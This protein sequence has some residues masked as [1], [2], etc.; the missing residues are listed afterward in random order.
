MLVQGK[1]IK[2]SHGMHITPEYD[3]SVLRTADMVIVP[4]WPSPDI[5]PEPQ[6]TEALG[7]LH[8]I[9]PPLWV[10]ALCALF[11]TTG[12]KNRVDTLVV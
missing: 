8:S 5:V 2:T 1:T 3:L 10:C 4:F 12:C 7:K 6:L 9:M 11:G